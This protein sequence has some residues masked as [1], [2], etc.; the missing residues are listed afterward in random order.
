M[1]VG[2]VWIAGMLDVLAADWLFALAGSRGVLPTYPRIHSAGMNDGFS[3]LSP[4]DT[5][6]CVAR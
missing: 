2:D 1:R 5:L 3:Y 6:C 4:A